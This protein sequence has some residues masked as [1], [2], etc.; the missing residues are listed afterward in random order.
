MAELDTL[1][2]LDQ[3]G[4]NAP[5]VAL[6]DTTIYTYSDNHQFFTSLSGVQATPQ[7]VTGNTL[8]SNVFK[9]DGLVFIGVTGST[10][11][12]LVMYRHNSGANSTWRLVLYE[13]TGIIGFPMIPNGGNLLVTWNSQGVFAL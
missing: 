6:V 11:G 7:A 2:S 9:G 10:I 13:D 4:V 12:A 1:K 3:A 8:V 5:Y